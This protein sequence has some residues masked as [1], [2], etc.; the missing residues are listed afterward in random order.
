LFSL[1]DFFTN[2]I[3]NFQNNKKFDL[4]SYFLFVASYDNVIAHA[5]IE[6]ENNSAKQIRLV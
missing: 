6:E 2:K 4:V 1:I 5:L 3:F